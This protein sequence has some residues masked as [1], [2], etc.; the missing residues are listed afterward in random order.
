M[1][2]YIFEWLCGEALHNILIPFVYLMQRFNAMKLYVY[3]RHF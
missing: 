2:L 3:L 1:D